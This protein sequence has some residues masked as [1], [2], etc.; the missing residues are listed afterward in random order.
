MQPREVAMREGWHRALDV[1]MDTHK[2][3]LSDL[4]AL[5]NFGFMGEVMSKVLDS[6]NPE[7]DEHALR[8]V[9]ISLSEVYVQALY[10]AD[11]L[12]ITSDM[13][14]MLLQAAHDL[15]EDAQ[16]DEHVLITPT[17][18]CLFEEPI[19]GV[20]RHEKKIL[21]H[22]LVWSKQLLQSRED[23]KDMGV[24]IF[25]LVDPTDPIDDYNTKFAEQ[26]RETGITLPPLALQH[27]YPARFGDTLPHTPEDQTVMGSLI[28]HET[29]KLFI[30]MQLVAQ[31]KIGEPIQMRPD[32]ATRRRYA[33]EYGGE[34]LITLITLRRKSVKKDDEE[35]AKVEWSRRWVVKGHWRRQWYPKSQTHDYVYIYEYVKGPEDK[36]LVLSERRVFNFAR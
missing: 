19:V 9:S 3:C 29:L 30:A 16:F 28:I 2:W 27:F 26:M 13:M 11:T 6:K 10:R 12:Y 20:D 24:V 5:Y 18:F 15:P 23:G 34:R 4:G 14:H 31:Q 8:L 36:P 32:R 33:R 22:G 21:I 17:G 7:M 35:A 1:Q 25:F